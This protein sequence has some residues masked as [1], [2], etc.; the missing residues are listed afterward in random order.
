MGQKAFNHEAKIGAAKGA[1]SFGFGIAKTLA[2]GAA[3]GNPGTA[4]AVNAAMSEP[5]SLQPSNNAQ[6][7]AAL[8]T[9]VGLTAATVSAL[10]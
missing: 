5:K 7:G 2:M 4:M 3:G 10:M 9:N 1:G 8:L 6:A